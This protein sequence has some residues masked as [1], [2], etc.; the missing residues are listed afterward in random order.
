MAKG[1]ALWCSDGANGVTLTTYTASDTLVDAAWSNVTTYRQFTNSDGN[2]LAVIYGVN[3]S[4]ATVNAAGA[5]V[6]GTFSASVG[7]LVGTPAPAANSIAY[8]AIDADLD[9]AIL[10]N[11]ETLILSGLT[12]AKAIT[13]IAGGRD[14]QKMTIIN[15]VAQNLTLTNASAASET[16]NKFTTITGGDVVTTGIGIVSMVY[17]GTARVWRAWLVAA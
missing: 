15:T 16:G 5:V 10:P 9:D 7:G 3:F 4:T 13:G 17:D 6:G 11:A 12:G 14:G 2:V 8:L 1:L